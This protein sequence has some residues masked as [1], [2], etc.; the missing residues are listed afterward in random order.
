MQDLEGTPIL[1]KRDER[2]FHA[3]SSLCPHLGC[4]VRWED[5][6]HRFF[7]PCHRGVFDENGVATEGPP[8]DA[9]QRLA[10]VPLRVDEG[11]GV[12]YMEVKDVKRGNA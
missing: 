3:Y 4:R 9:G 6:N 5:D 11:A 1:I 8:A 12:V 7:C 10:E 2:G